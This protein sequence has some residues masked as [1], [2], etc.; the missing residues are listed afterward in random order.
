[1]LITKLAS[2]PWP[3]LLLSSD[4]AV[5]G[6]SPAA[7][8]LLGAVPPNIT[9]LEERFELLAADGQPSTSQEHPLHG[10]VRGEPLDLEGT[11]RDRHSGR[12]LGLR[13]RSMAVGEHR[14][15][16]IDSRAE[17]GDRRATARLQQLN[18]SL[19]GRAPGQ[20]FVSIRELL[21]QLVV[22]ACE[23]TQ[24]RYGALG[25]LRPDG[26]SLQDFI[27]VGIPEE[28]ATAIGHLPTGRGL[29]GAVIREA[30]T[31]RVAD[32]SR[33]PRSVGF[34]PG[35]PPMKS[36]LGVP[37]RVGDQAFGNFYLAD[38]QGVDEFTKE[39]ARL[40]ESF[41][42]QASLT[43][44][45]ARQV[46]QEERRLF[47][48]V[49]KYAPHGIAFFP[50]EHGGEVLANPAAER[51][52]GCLARGD[53]PERSYDLKHPDGRLL[54]PDELPA[55]RAMREEALINVEVVIERHDGHVTPALVSGAPV[56]SDTGAKLG[57]VVIYQ[58]ITTLKE[59]QSLR[60]EFVALV[61]HDLRTPVQAV[62]MHVEALL[63]RAS[64]GAASVPVTTLESMKRTGQR[65]DQLVRSLLEASSVDAKGVVLDRKPVNLADLVQ[66]L[67][68]QV[69][70]TLA[71][72]PIAVD[73]TGA[74]P[75]VSAD[76]LRVEQIVTNLLEN[77]V[78]YSAQETPIRIGIA[79]LGSGATL[80]VEDH[81]PGISPEDVPHLFDRYFQTRRARA[82][83]SGLGLGLYITKGL[84]DAHGG[85]ITVKSTPGVGS[86]FSVWLPG[87]S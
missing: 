56:R 18:E 78:K 40:L 52:I 74:P 36:F 34:P 79:R 57:A 53:D 58:D 54:T 49:V 13:F 3:A 47:E 83:R 84:V 70:G 33:D 65:L 11:W 82:K 20:G 17:D 61:A 23:L 19:L 50:V 37:L 60:E 80:T 55:R 22:H 7:A 45:Y 81:G 38:K 44:A 16:Q 31:V 4:G 9:A 43:V 76:P 87:H 2:I 41:S 63:L 39:D 6:A 32:M 59:L 5:V 66:S 73:V 85:T 48:A 29:L 1:V 10:A 15:L 28:T 86:A 51:M 71:T 21:R 8:E 35:H 68:A 27:Y 14:L 69:Q 12:Q 30:R 62:L 64:G 24:A 26:A 72:H 75:L 67:V 46:Q 42:A 25:V 77:A